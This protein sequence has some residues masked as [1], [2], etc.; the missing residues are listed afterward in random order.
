M[1]Q[2]NIHAAKTHL[3]ALVDKAAAG[4]PFIIAKSGRPLVTVIPYVAEAPKPR[5][6]FLKA[7]ASVPDDFDRIGSEEIIGMFEGE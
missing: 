7:R 4:E 3:S 5:V 1:Q 2:V 6:G